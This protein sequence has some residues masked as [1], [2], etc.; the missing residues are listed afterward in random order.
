MKDLVR[1][2]LFWPVV[3]LVA[4]LAANTVKKP[5]FLAL[6]VIDGHL[7]G[8]TIN[9]LR[10]GAPL[11][12]VAL[13]MTL[14]IA[15]RGID[16]SV[17][18]VVAIAAAVGLTTVAGSADPGSLGAVL[19]A[20]ATAL[21]V[22]VLAGLWN[23]FLVSVLGI[24]PIIATL[25]LMTAGRGIAMLITDGQITTVTSGPFKA[26]GSGFWLGLP[27]PVL[28]AAAVM[29]AVALLTRRTALGMLVES[30]GV[31]PEASRIAGVGSRTI[32]WTVY[33]VCALF[34]G[35]AGLMI[36]ANTMAAD[37]NNA[38]LFI[39]LDAILAVVIGGTSLAGGKFSLSGTLVG[40]LVI[41]T[42]TL[43][44]TMLGIATSVTPLFKAAVVIAVCL[45][46]SPAVRE[47]FAARRRRRVAPAAA[48]EVA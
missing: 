34:S 3:A 27:I 11:L 21:G 33:V 20:F 43:S 18:A 45:A 40:V 2:R 7:F 9:L 24:Q 22:C 1:H 35:L 5:S 37:A 38:G 31:N 28:L 47:R 36:A 39:E 23:G 44:V 8:A 32:V 41:Q 4:L 46:Q 42:L 30:V 13:G 19:V 10:Q 17:G 29:V 6:E 25:V 12:L 15:T 26:I 16:L 48:V 14:V